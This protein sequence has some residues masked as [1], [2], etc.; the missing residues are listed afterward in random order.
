M[1]KLY[2]SLCRDVFSPELNSGTLK[3]N[4]GHASGLSAGF[5]NEP[6]FLVLG[7]KQELSEGVM[8]LLGAGEQQDCGN[9][10]S[11]ITQDELSVFTSEDICTAYGESPVPR[12]GTPAGALLW[13]SVLSGSFDRNIYECTRE[14]S[15]GRRYSEREALL[16]PLKLDQVIS[17]WTGDVLGRL[18]K[19]GNP[20]ITASSGR[21][22]F[23]RLAG[24]YLA[25][26][27]FGCSVYSSPFGDRIPEAVV[28][29]KYLTGLLVN[30]I[31]L[32]VSEFMF[33]AGDI[34]CGTNGICEHLSEMLTMPVAEVKPDAGS[35]LSIV[36]GKERT[37]AMIRTSLRLPELMKSLKIMDELL[38]VEITSS[39]FDGVVYE[40][41]VNLMRRNVSLNQAIKYLLFSQTVNVK[42]KQRSLRNNLKDYFDVTNIDVR[43]M[44]NFGDECRS[45]LRQCT[46]RDK[47]SGNQ[48][49]ELEKMKKSAA[50]YTGIVLLLFSEA[51]VL[52]SSTGI[53]KNLLNSCGFSV[54]R[55]F[56]RLVDRD[57][58]GVSA[59]LES[60][61][62]KESPEAGSV[63][64]ESQS[65]DGSCSKP[66]NKKIQ[67]RMVKFRVMEAQKLAPCIE[68]VV[69]RITS[70]P[71]IEV[72]YL[73]LMT[74]LTA[75][76]T[77]ERLMLL[78]EKDLQKILH[79][80]YSGRKVMLVQWCYP[81]RRKKRMPESAE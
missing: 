76:K 27:L 34:S 77:R 21:G 16:Y 26:N 1:N 37:G 9:D 18:L 64:G 40:I 72:V 56:K 23:R 35:G 60:F 48:L 53:Y 17:G 81:Y 42:N 4:F 25:H 79:D 70:S 3:T 12:E 13:Q 29:Q 47:V 19:Y 28:L 14:Y 71:R 74:V 39:K 46:N 33:E 45:R 68:G 7:V 43:N 67:N 57:S 32:A 36:P 22:V 73:A 59:F 75:V 10:I 41:A 49:A 50:Y 24:G 51:E 15:L 66:A 8:K 69:F 55:E 78:F 52:V 38:D 44:L 31:G 61:F 6:F 62:N 5:I 58:E 54:I 63:P 80:F 2:T 65:N 20:G 30:R 11:E